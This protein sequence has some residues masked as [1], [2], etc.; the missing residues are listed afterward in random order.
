MEVIELIV[1]LVVVYHKVRTG[2]IR[3]LADLSEDFSGSASSSPYFA[4][5]ESV[6]SMGSSKLQR[7][8]TMTKTARTRSGS[9]GHHASRVEAQNEVVAKRS[10]VAGQ[11]SKVDVNKN[12]VA[13]EVT[14]KKSQVMLIR[15]PVTAKKS[16]VSP[17]EK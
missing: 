11:K 7:A 5:A 15:N 17:K 2:K 9:T 6:S 13:A 1:N 14:E 10:E 4:S 16:Q 8:M 12:E 3:V